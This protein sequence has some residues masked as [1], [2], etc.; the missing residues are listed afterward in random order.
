MSG[1]DWLEI[2]QRVLVAEFARLK[3]RLA[4]EDSHGA[5][6]EL[7]S[8]RAALPAPSA[9]DV[10]VE[11]FGLSPFERDFLLLCAGVEMDGALASHCARLNGGAGLAHATFGLALALLAEPHWSAITPVGP[12]RQW[13]LIELA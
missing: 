5:D 1:A 8:A 2:N 13:R 12:L 4:A 11:L 9:I 6:D 10:L 7:A 3:T